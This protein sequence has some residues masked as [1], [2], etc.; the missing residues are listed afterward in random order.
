MSADGGLPFGI[1]D[2]DIEDPYGDKDLRNWRDEED[3]KIRQAEE[4]HDEN[5]WD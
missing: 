5:V 1:S 3:E 4:K 2:E